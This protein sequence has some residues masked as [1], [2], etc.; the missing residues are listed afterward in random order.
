MPEISVVS[1][2]SLRMADIVRVSVTTEQVWRVVL[3]MAAQE[4][5]GLKERGE[6]ALRY[7][8]AEML[9]DHRGMLCMCPHRNA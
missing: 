6:T 2:E 5:D 9:L 7:W 3:S 8:G 4:W 1:D